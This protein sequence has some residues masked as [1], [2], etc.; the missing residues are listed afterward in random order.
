MESFLKPYFCKSQ[1]FHFRIHT[2]THPNEDKINNK[3]KSG[4]L[5][6]NLNQSSYERSSQSQR[7][8]G[9]QVIIKAMIDVVL[10]KIGFSRGGGETVGKT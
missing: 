8:T 1:I 10:V 4:A 7:R 5:D 3:E 6:N 2:Q 9:G